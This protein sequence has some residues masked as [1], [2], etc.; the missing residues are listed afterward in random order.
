MSATLIENLANF[1]VKT[2]FDQLP[3]T[4]VDESK[5][6][7][8]DSIGCALG[9][10]DDAKGRIGVDYGRLIGGNTG[11]AT[12]IGT[13][14]R[15]S[16][17]GAAF[18]NGE[19]ISALDFDSVLP[20]GHV[21]PYVLP[22]AMAVGETN[23]VSGKD[24]LNVIAISHEMSYRIGK[25]T[26]YLRD[27]KD[28]K[29][30]PP[31][32]Y[33]YSSTVFGATAA[34]AR[35]NGL[36]AER[37]ANALGIAGSIAPVNSHRA[38]SQHAPSTTIKYLMAGVLVQTAMTA[39]YMGEM[40]HRGDLKTLDDPEFGF[41]RF[42]GTTRWE[43]GRILPGLG[44]EWLFPAEQSYK[45]YPHC[46]ILHALLDCLIQL[47]KEHD[48]KPSEIDGIDALVE[49][50]VLQPIWLNN[51]IEH[52]QDAQ[53]SIAHGLAV[54]AHGIPPGKAWQDPKVV[55]D[56]SVLALM[57]KVTYAIHPDYEREL[58]AH[59]ASRPARIEVRAR[60]QTFVRESLYPKGSPS[61]DPSSYMTTE[62]LIQ[63]FRNNAES[64]IPSATID[65]VL[66]DLLHLENVNNFSTIMC[67]LSN[68]AGRHG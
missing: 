55:Y 56:P 3:P 42:I 54:G 40:G 5:R 38:W 14:D 2:Q 67:Q 58:Q 64:V 9:G 7:L 63:K 11:P 23:G 26:D 35:L 59:A 18:A 10:I 68:P 8:L 27:I 36:S 61:P 45:P 28:G 52:T 24:L 16:I 37:T 25:A 50:F 1:T 39:A 51:R 66:D 34:I 20:P 15:T 65:R 31:K 17:F 49:G 33:G 21:C 53:F 6:I 19:L 32:I 12:I 47:T 62:E 29:V 13:G 41:P 46:R 4:V 43:S 57:A 48:I 30:T 22:G 60:G 44:E